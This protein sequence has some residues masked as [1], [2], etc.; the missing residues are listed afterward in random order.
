MTRTVDATIFQKG[1]MD[2][3][4]TWIGDGPDMLDCFRIQIRELSLSDR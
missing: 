1:L 4:E 2:L 3:V